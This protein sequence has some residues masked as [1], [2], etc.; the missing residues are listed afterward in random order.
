MPQ[1]ICKNGNRVAILNYDGSISWAEPSS[2]NL[3]AEWY[4]TT[5]GQWFEY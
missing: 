4:L 5:D 2:Q 3:T 1:T